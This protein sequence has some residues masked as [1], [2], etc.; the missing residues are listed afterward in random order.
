MVR[1]GKTQCPK[2]LC[3]EKQPNY[4]HLT[5]IK[6]SFTKHTTSQKIR[7][8]SKTYQ[9]LPTKNTKNT[10]KKIIDGCTGVTFNIPYN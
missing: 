5:R 6:T 1:N 10:K 9:T 7:S 4:Q 2:N 3:L 8:T